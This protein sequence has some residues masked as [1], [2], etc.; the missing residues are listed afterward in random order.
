MNE[1]RN[2]SSNKGG[3]PMQR[4]MRALLAG[5]AAA[6]LA[7][8]QALAATITVAPGA[9][10]Q[11]AIDA[12]N[13][14]D[15]IKLLNGRHNQAFV[16]TKQLKVQGESKTLTILDGS[17][18]GQHVIQLDNGV[19]SAVVKNLTMLFS[20]SNGNAIRAHGNDLSSFEGLVVKGIRA[21][22]I[23]IYGSGTT[24]K[25]G[26]FRGNRDAAVYSQ[27]SGSN[28]FQGN[29]V[30]RGASGISTVSDALVKSNVTEEVQNGITATGNTHTLYSNNGRRVTG[31]GQNAT[32]AQATFYKG[33]WKSVGGTAFYVDTWAGGSS[34]D[35]PNAKKVGSRGIH[36]VNNSVNILSP[37]LDTCDHALVSTAYATTVTGGSVK[38]CRMGVQLEGDYSSIS[39]VTFKQIRGEA[40]GFH[41]VYNG[42]IHGNMVTEAGQDPYNAAV[43]MNWCEYGRVSGNTIGDVDGGDAIRVRTT[44]NYPVQVGGYVGGYPAGNII[45]DVSGHGIAMTYPTNAWYG[46]SVVQ[47]NMLTR[48]GDLDRAAIGVG[49]RSVG[50][51]SN[52]ITDAGG[53]GIRFDYNADY[54]IATG[55][56]ITNPGTNG[57]L[58]MGYVYTWYD[59]DCV[60]GYADNYWPG[61]GYY[62]N[63]DYVC[64]DYDY[65]AIS[66]VNGADFCDING[67][68]IT[69]AGTE[70]IEIRG[71]GTRVRNNSVSGSGIYDIAVMF[72]GLN[73]GGNYDGDDSIDTY[74]STGNSPQPSSWG[75]APAPRED[76]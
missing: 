43:T 22:A 21:N 53:T 1:N 50:V 54:G 17:G 44:Y 10:I 38:N 72:Y 13:P 26:L 71:Q 76:N 8:S 75:A 12:A 24:V 9:S 47:F 14:G 45:T 46:A 28:L 58:V 51:H 15:T 40:I 57:I 20:D 69:G 34:M 29:K 39:G 31:T 18:L 41:G 73:G 33:T 23:E 55:N 30:Y 64:T 42:V 63:W 25:S 3:S 65:V 60:S 32:C 66:Y 68:T 7:S 49:S 6:V 36:A 62:A 16:I 27:A 4:R 56:T 11:D 19:A 48:V 61:Y 74:Y 59:Y 5:A 35:T 67:N 37:K 52:S 70:G 2:D